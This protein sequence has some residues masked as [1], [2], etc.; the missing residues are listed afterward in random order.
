LNF[1]KTIPLILLDKVQIMQVILNL[2]RNSIEA[3]QLSITLNPC[4]MIETEVNDEYVLVH[5][6]DNGPGIAEEFKNKIL[7]TYF[8]SKSYGTG[9]GLIICRSLIEA[10]GGELCFID[11]PDQGAWF[12]IKLPKKRRI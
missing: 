9:L 8:T 12:Q 2:V 5:C 11:I 7:N 3:L 1:T 6:R 4:I 10:H